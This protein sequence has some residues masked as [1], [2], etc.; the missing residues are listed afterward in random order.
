MRST[1][2]SLICL[3]VLDVVFFI[4]SLC[5]VIQPSNIQGMYVQV[6]SNAC[7]VQMLAI[8]DVKHIPKACS[9]VFVFKM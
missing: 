3:H 5:A 6:Q 7:Q 2:L 4:H 1:Y 8:T 9:C